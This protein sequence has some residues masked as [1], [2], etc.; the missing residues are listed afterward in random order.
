MQNGEN[1]EPLGIETALCGSPYIETAVVFG[2]DEKFLAALIV[3]SK[4]GIT[5]YAEEHGIPSGNYEELIARPEIEDLIRCEIDTIISASNGFKPCERVY[6]F[7]IL[8][9]SFEIGREL[10]AKQEFMRHKVAEL[11]K[12]KIAEMFE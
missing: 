12:D 6:R 7:C 2:Q 1:I 8:A 5:S 4:T 9:D 10:S 11:Y 3:G